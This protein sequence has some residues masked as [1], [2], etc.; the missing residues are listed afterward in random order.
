MP[1]LNRD[2]FLA[3]AVTV[4][5]LLPG[6]DIVIAKGGSTKRYMIRETE[7]Y[8]GTGD[9]ACHASKGRTRR[10]EVMY[11]QGGISISILSTG[12]TGC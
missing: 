8:L 11:M 12:C 2:F 5:R 1:G 10:T 3:D 4:A 7:A 9:R 6:M